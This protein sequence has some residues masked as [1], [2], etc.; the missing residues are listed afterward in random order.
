[1]H[2]QCCS[3]DATNSY[4]IMLFQQRMVP[5]SLSK[6]ENQTKLSINIFTINRTASSPPRTTFVKPKINVDDRVAKTIPRFSR[7]LFSCVNGCVVI[8][9]PS[10]FLTILAMNFTH[11]C[12]GGVTLD[13]FRC[14]FSATIFR[15]KV[16][17]LL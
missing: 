10:Y 17:I 6:K 16:L 5:P 13:S 7:L 11:P 12:I 14:F 1:M 8:W 2:V 4:T 9:L 15:K 3:D